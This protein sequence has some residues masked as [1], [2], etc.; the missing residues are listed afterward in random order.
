MKSSATPRPRRRPE[1]AGR[2]YVLLTAAAAVTGLGSHGALVAAAFAVLESGGDGGDVGLVAAARTLPLVVFLLIGG[3]VADRLPRHRVMVAANALNCV[4]QGVFAALV[5]T[6]RAELWQ[7]LVLSA[8]GGTGQAF[9]SPA[10]EG[11]LM[12][13]VGH[14][15]ASRAFAL[16]RMA[17]S[18]A[19]IGGAAL[20][21]ALVAAFGP[22]WVLAVDAAA[23]AAAG[24][25]RVFLDVSHVPERA[26]A[27]GCSPT[28]ARGGT[29]SSAAPGCGRSSRS[30]PWSSPSSAPPSPCTGRWS[31]RS[32][33]AARGRGAWPWPRS[34]WAR[35]AARC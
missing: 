24:A 18:G 31:R 23:F 1:W 4:S 12:S 28:C 16:F 2:N 35:S 22:G 34:A 32:R 6:G 14:G 30:S 21:G 27:A 20:G 11:M 26:P 10:A 5:L 17:V 25:L 3:A 19:A 29:S 15:Q 9:F 33:W 13:S 7:M 8:L